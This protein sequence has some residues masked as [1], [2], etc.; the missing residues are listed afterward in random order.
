MKTF[1]YE[2]PALKPDKGKKNGSCNVTAC[3][4]PGA[5][6]FNKSTKKYYCKRCADEINWPGG[7]ALTRE[8]YG[9]DL[10]CELD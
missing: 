6:Y 8:L 1:N 9:T 2:P 7:R 5:L 10:L 3:Q 4:A